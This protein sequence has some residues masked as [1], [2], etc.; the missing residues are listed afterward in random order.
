MLQT[1]FGVKLYLKPDNTFFRNAL[2]LDTNNSVSVDP[3]FCLDAY[4]GT[5]Y[6]FRN[7]KS[8]AFAAGPEIGVELFRMPELKTKYPVSDD[9]INPFVSAFVG[10]YATYYVKQFTFSAGYRHYLKTSIVTEKGAFGM[11]DRTMYINIDNIS[12]G[13]GIRLSRNHASRKY[14]D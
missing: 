6:F 2:G 11:P 4:I 14:Q 12:V 8:H 7:T 9:N 5:P 3:T 10:V 13:V 1:M